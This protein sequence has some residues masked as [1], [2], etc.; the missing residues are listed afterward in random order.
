MKEIID[1]IFKPDPASDE[2]YK[3]GCNCG[4]NDEWKKG[5]IDAW[6]EGVGQIILRVCNICGNTKE[7]SR[8]Y[9]QQGRY[10]CRECYPGDKAQVFD[11]KDSP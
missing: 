8:I 10:A 4:P 2:A 6:N 3:V 7:C 5:R 1:A 9:D 11:G